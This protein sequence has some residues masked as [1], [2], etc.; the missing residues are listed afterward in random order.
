MFHCLTGVHLGVQIRFCSIWLDSYSTFSIKATLYKK[1]VL[2][3]FWW[4]KLI[5]VINCIYS[6]ARNCLKRWSLLDHILEENTN[7]ILE[8]QI[9]LNWLRKSK[10]DSFCVI[11]IPREYEI[12]LNF[13]L[14]IFWLQF[15]YLCWNAKYL[16]FNCLLVWCSDP[17][18]KW[19]NPFFTIWTFFYP[20][21]C[22]EAFQSKIKLLDKKGRMGRNLWELLLSSWNSTWWFSRLVHDYY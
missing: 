11:P 14:T 13:F 3:N 19:A 9:E 18:A 10:W 5:N 6:F 15:V 2:F 20:G 7:S 16:G 4:I 8:F 22:K 1:M 21:H 17:R 12:E